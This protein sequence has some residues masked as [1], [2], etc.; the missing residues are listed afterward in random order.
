M[1]FRKKVDSEPKMINSQ[2]CLHNQSVRE[3][4]PATVYLAD[5][6]MMTSRSVRRVISKI[7]S[8][9][10]FGRVGTDSHEGG[11]DEGYRDNAE[12]LT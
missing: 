11:I 6:S 3:R 4:Y 7:I 2:M 8:I 10:P 9:P 5:Q 12:S 1:V